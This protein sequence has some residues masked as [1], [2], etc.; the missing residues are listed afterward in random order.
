MIE[1]TQLVSETGKRTD[2]GTG[3]VCPIFPGCGDSARSS[4]QQSVVELAR[5]ASWSPW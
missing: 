2:P 5:E 3:I 1:T 4:A